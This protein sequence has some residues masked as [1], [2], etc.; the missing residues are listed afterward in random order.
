M[1]RSRQNALLPE[2]MNGRDKGTNEP[3]IATCLDLEDKVMRASL[4]LMLVGLMLQAPV[5]AAQE[6][7]PGKYTGQINFTWVG[8]PMQEM[9]TLSVDKVQGNQIEGVAWVGTKRCQ[10]DTPVQGR[11]DGDVLKVTGKAVKEDCGIRWELK[12]VGN[13]LEG[14]T[15]GG[16]TI[17]LSKVSAQAVTAKCAD[18]DTQTMTARC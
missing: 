13:K 7:A 6:L 1:A 16:S 15:P 10:V 4:G 11:L 12:V 18:A 5:V 2:H 3:G 17:S 14:T 8:K 9:V